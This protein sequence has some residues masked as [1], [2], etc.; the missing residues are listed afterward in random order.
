MTLSADEFLRRLLLHLLPKGFVRIRNFGY[1]SNRRR[2]I[3]LPLCFQLLGS[4]PNTSTTEAQ[5][6][7][8]SG[9]WRCPQCG[10]PMIVTLRV[11]PAK[12]LIRSPPPEAAVAQGT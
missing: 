2:H 5:Q 7:I 3:L 11:S 8:P 10:G 12:R 6:V 4:D 9:L 1:L